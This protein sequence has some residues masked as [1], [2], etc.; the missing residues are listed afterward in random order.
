MK[1]TLTKDEIRKVMN[2]PKGCDIE[3]DGL[4]EIMKGENVID[5]DA[6]PRIPYD[7]WKVEEHKKGGQFT[8]NPEKVKLFLHNKQKNG[9]TIE[10][11]KLRK[12]LSHTAVFNAN[13][14]DYLLDNQQFIPDEWKGKIIFFW[15]TIYRISDGD[16]CVRY[17]GWSGSQWG[18]GSY[19]LG[20][21]FGG[22]FPAA[23]VAS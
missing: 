4:N 15:G 3:I 6:D 23:V 12:E 14:L 17:L 11:N 5:L 16:L 13:L 19:W 9:K 7:G 20:G 22:S 8:W 1:I 10:G 21:D 18:W 2:L